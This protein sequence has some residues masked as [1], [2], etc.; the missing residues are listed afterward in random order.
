V[1]VAETRVDIADPVAELEEAPALIVAV[2]ETP[3][4]HCASPFWSMVAILGFSEDQLPE[5]GA[6][7]GT[8]TVAGE[9]G[10][11]KLPVATNCTCPP[12]KFCASAFAGVRAIEVR[13][14]LLVEDDPHAVPKATNKTAKANAEQLKTVCLFMTNS[15]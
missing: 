13:T 11:L 2:P 3:A 12:A 9:G 5:Y 1:A 4:T 8:G 10:L 6:T 15:V 7:N 14:R